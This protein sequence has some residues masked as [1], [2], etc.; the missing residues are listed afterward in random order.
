MLW[1]RAVH[2][3]VCDLDYTPLFANAIAEID[4]ACDTFV[5][6]IWRTRRRRT[7]AHQPALL[8][9]LGR[10]LSRLRILHNSASD[11]L[12]AA[13][14]VSATDA[15]RGFGELLARVRYRRESFLIRKG[16][17]VVAR[18][19]PAGSGGM[20]GADL[21][22]LWDRLPHLEEAEARAFERD[23]RAGRKAIRQRLT[24]PW[25]H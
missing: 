11:R 24:D 13:R 12:V 14:I 20:S 16:R 8:D 2:G 10:A 7:R 18:L 9:R 23:L 21:A 3:N 25:A 15:A 1:P 6:P 4:T 5:P 17:V 19:E 22:R